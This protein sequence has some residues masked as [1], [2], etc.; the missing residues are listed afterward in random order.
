MSFF[1]KV[2]PLTSC[3]TPARRIVMSFILNDQNQ[4][5]GDP[6]GEYL[7][8]AVALHCVL[9]VHHCCSTTLLFSL[10]STLAAFIS[11]SLSSSPPLFFSSRS[12]PPPPPS[13]ESCP[14]F[15]SHLLFTS[16]SPPL[17]VFFYLHITLLLLFAALC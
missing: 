10:I 14:S 3:L 8:A 2:F 4:Y 5:V 6:D 12:A 9:R 13:S 11:T 7:Y 17:Q 1:L 15:L 16:L